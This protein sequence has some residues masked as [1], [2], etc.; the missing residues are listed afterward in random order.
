MS[1]NDGKDRTD[2]AIFRVM[3]E[4][5]TRDVACSMILQ[6]LGE[7]LFPSYMAHRVKNVLVL[8]SA[9]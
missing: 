7:V 9:V 5:Y 1:P 2:T 8:T 4:K 3:D 6:E